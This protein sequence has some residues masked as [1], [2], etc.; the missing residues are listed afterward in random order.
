V[1]KLRPLSHPD[2]LSRA[3][4]DCLALNAPCRFS[5]LQQGGRVHFGSPWVRRII[6]C[7]P[8]NALSC[9]ND[10]KTARKGN[11]CCN[12]GR[13]NEG[14]PG[15]KIAAALLHLAESGLSTNGSVG[16]IAPSGDKC[17][18]WSLQPFCEASVWGHH[19][20]SERTAREFRQLAP[21]RKTRGVPTQRREGTCAG[22]SDANSTWRAHCYRYRRSCAMFTLP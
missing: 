15:L 8:R 14:E 1:L 10:A 6:A 5:R 4:Q 7:L 11:R 17:G 16:L 2:G 21:T 20:S 22:F 9:A 19:Y 3:R 18:V 13:V 12:K